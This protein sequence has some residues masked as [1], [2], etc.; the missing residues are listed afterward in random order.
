MGAG[1]SPSSASS[2]SA[3]GAIGERFAAFLRGGAS[4]PAEQLAQ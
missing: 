3:G 4:T 1:R 2:R